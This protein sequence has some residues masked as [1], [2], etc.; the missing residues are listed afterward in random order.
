MRDS[1]ARRANGRADVVQGVGVVLVLFLALRPGLMSADS[2][3]QLG[4]AR[5]FTFNDWHPVLMA[6]TWG[7]LRKLFGD[8]GLLLAHLTLFEVGLAMLVNAFDVGTVR[9]RVALLL[10][11]FPPVLSQVGVLWKDTGLFCVWI[12]ALG[13]AAQGRGR[14]LKA[15]AA[16]AVLAELFVCYGCA[17]RIN[18]LPAGIIINMLIVRLLFPNVGALDK[19]FRRVVKEGGAAGVALPLVFGLS[20]VAATIVEPVHA[21]SVQAVMIYDLALTGCEHGPIRIPPVFL[22]PEATTSSICAVTNDRNIDTLLYNPKVVKLTRTGADYNVLKRAWVRAVVADPIRYLRIRGKVFLHSMGAFSPLSDTYIMQKGIDPNFNSLGVSFRPN[23]VSR[24]IFGFVDLSVYD[25]PFLFRSYFWALI[26]IALL[27]LQ[28]GDRRIAAVTSRYLV[29]SS[30]VYLLTWIPLV[31]ANQFRYFSWTVVG[32]VL[33]VLLTPPSLR[34]R[35]ADAMSD[36]YPSSAATSSH[37][38]PSPNATPSMYSHPT[39]PP[40]ELDHPDPTPPPSHPSHPSRH[41]DP[42]CPTPSNTLSKNPFKPQQSAPSSHAIASYS[43][44]D[45]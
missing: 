14:S 41:A 5:S 15:R 19:S 2:L 20:W 25:L 32:I 28:R 36:P 37:A 40:H 35:T 1:L 11:F 26:G 45:P 3:D 30:L 17:I 22:A 21:Y 10:P 8:S 33:A 42:A 38:P 29:V 31:V 18:A 16:F 4:Q 34:R 6:V 12:F 43:Q 23:L 27:F 24:A 13:L 9:R 39:P 44:A 7:W